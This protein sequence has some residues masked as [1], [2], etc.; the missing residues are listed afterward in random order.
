MAVEAS[1]LPP[2]S[3]RF[4]EWTTCGGAVA[5]PDSALHASPFD[6]VR[7]RGGQFVM[8]PPPRS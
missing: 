8:A 5:P 4:R 2:Y 6:A 1:R 7:C 3:A